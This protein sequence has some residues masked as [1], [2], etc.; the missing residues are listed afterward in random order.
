[1]NICID[2]ILV[3]LDFANHVFKPFYVLFCIPIE[4]LHGVEALKRRP[5]RITQM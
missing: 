5:V 2:A 1:M 3:V 4:G